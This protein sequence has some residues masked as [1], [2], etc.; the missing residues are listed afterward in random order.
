MDK[1]TTA[2]PPLSFGDF[3]DAQTLIHIYSIASPTINVEGGWG[4]SGLV[5]LC[6]QLHSGDPD[7]FLEYT[8]V[9]LAELLE[10][11]ISESNH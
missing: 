8:H 4:K 3:G 11:G 6:L 9:V 5:K 10:V 2:P 7:L 1:S